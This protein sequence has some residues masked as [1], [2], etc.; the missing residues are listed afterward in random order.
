MYVPVLTHI[1]LESPLSDDVLARLPMGVQVLHAAAQPPIYSNAA[2]AQAIIASSQVRYDGALMDACPNL[3]LIARTGIGVDNIDLDAATARG[4]VVT[5][6]PD[7]PTESTAEHTVAMLL[8]LA[9]RLKQGADNLAAGKWGPRTGAL[10]GVEVR[11]KT[12]GLVGLGRIGTQVALRCRAFGMEIMA[13][14]PYVS[15]EKADR[16]GVQLVD[17]LKGGMALADVITLHVPLTKE[18]RGMLDAATLRACKRGAYL[19]NC[20]R[21][22]LVDE[23]ACAE[24]VRSGILAGTAF[25]VFDGEPVRA[26]HPLLASDIRGK[27]ILTPHIGANTEEAQSAVAAI[28]ASNLAAALLGKPY[29]HAVNLP[30]SEQLL[31]DGS[32][33]YLSLARKMGYLAA[34]LLREPVREIKVALR[35]PLFT[36]G[37]EPVC[38]EVPYHYS[39]FTVAGLKGMLEFSHGPEVNYMSAPLLAEDKGIAV[40][41]TRA[42]GGTYRNLLE[43][44]ITSSGGRETVTVCGTVTEEGRQRVV[45]LDGYPIEFVPEGV[46]LLFSNHDRPGVIGKVGTLLGEAGSNIANFALGRVLPDRAAPG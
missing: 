16:A 37:D 39:P 9:K 31:S 40:E 11:G 6:T 23:E 42:D 20:A 22:G 45:K 15:K 19:V 44:S 34:N 18:S 7:G 8:A 24:A 28:A 41:E 3:K 12:L 26:D 10:V 25:D 1:W 27:V 32:R 35:G 33:A 5:N 4:V 17:D 36:C 46:V 14:D 30:F 2:P 43:L 29:E 13:F 38:F 21:G